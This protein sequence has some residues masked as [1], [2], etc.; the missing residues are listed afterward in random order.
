LH[1]HFGYTG[2]ESSVEYT[3]TATTSTSQHYGQG[4]KGLQMLKT[5]KLLFTDQHFAQISLENFFH[6]KFKSNSILGDHPFFDKMKLNATPDLEKNFPAIRDEAIEV[7]KRYEEIAP[8]QMISPDQLHLSNDDRWKLFFL[9]AAN[10]R[11][12]KN[13][14]MM[15]KTRSVLDRNPEICSAY[16]SILGRRKHLPPH[17]GPWAGLLRAHLG[18]IIPDTERCYIRVANKNYHWKNG[19]VVYFDDTYEHEA[20]NNTDE[21]RVVLFMDILRPM[22]FPYN[23]LNKFLLFIA[24]YLPYVKV[25]LQR[26]REWEKT[27]HKEI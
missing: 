19:E 23:Y 10:I 27:F 18:L 2:Q 8:F 24:R 9:K 16:L 15:P 14:A 21:I 22:K 1:H 17:C 7:L 26:H 3:H 13:L 4:D 20:F 25:P 11:F 12:E 5:L 6:D